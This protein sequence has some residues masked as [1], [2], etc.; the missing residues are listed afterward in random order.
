MVYAKYT[1]LV[2]FIKDWNIESLVVR[3]IVYI[4][5]YISREILYLKDLP[6]SVLCIIESGSHGC[7]FIAF[8]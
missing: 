7:S 4:Y 2:F 8:H 6:S 5:I 3:A 1:A